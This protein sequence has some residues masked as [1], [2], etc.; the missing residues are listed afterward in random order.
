MTVPTT[1]VKFSDVWSEANGTYTSGSLSLSAMSFYSY[2]SGPNGSNTVPDKNWG[3]GENSGADRIYGTTPKT[4]NI[5]VG[6][7]KG[8]TY[9]YDQSNF[10]IVLDILN[11]ATRTPDDDV[12]VALTL[13]D[14]GEN[15]IY[16]SGGA[17]VEGGGTS[18]T[19]NISVSTTPII[20]TGYW[21][22]DVV[23]GPAFGGNVVSLDIN[24]NNVMSPQGLVQNTTNTFYWFDHASGEVS[25]YGGATGL[26]FYVEI[27]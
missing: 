19:Q 11:N 20:N 21:Q 22:L 14:S 17:F 26:Y 23:T 4:T 2:F 9:Y 12:T 8:L 27:Q 7:F 13:W 5:K 18:N 10:E 16:N 15:Y 24:G 1:D 25:P 6:D 3:Q